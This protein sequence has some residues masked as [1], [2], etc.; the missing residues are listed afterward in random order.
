MITLKLNSEKPIYKM[1]PGYNKF[2][3]DLVAK[4]SKKSSNVS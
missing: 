1:F 4:T 3:K 2:N